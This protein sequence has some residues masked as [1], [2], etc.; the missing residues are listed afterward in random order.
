MI[1]LENTYI[2]LKDGRKLSARIWLPDDAQDNPGPANLEYLPYRKRDGTAARDESTY[3]VF[4]EAGYAGVRVDISGTGE[5]DG[6]FDDEYSPRE[7]ADGL[8]VIDWIASQPWCDGNIGMMGISWGGFNSLQ[9]A[10]LRPEPLKAVIAIG[11]T[12]DRYNDDIHYKNGCHLYSNFSWSSVMLCYASRPPDPVLVGDEWK[13]MWIYRLRTQPFPLE[14]WLTHQRR[15]EYWKHGSVCEN[16]EG[17]LIPTLVISGWADGYLN[18]PP[19]MVEN[20]LS[21]SRAINGPWIH[22]YPHFAWPKPRMDFHGEAIAWWDRWLKGIENGVE[23]MPGYR[24]YISER[25]RPVGYRDFESGRWVAETQWPSPNIK[26]TGFY[27]ADLG[28]LDLRSGDDER[29]TVCSPQDCGISCG[30]IF[31]LKPD[32]E[33]PGDQRI[34]DGGSLVFDSDV[35]PQ[36]VEILGRPTLS[37]RV[38]I[39][40]PVGN[41]AARLCDVHPDGMS[42]RVSWGVLNLAHREGNEYPSPMIPGIDEDITIQLNECGYRFLPGH[43]LRLSISTAYWPMVMPPPEVTIANIEMGRNSILTLPVRSGGDSIRVAEPA[44]PNPLPNYKNHSPDAHQRSVT[45]DM[46]HNMTHYRVFDDT[47]E[48]EV[49]G[50]GMRT[51]HTHEEVWSIS[52]EDP[53]S[54]AA[55]SEYICYMS[56]ENWRIRTVSHSSMACDA[57][58]YYLKASVD[59]YE[60]DELVNNRHWEKTIKRCFQ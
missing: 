5:S 43:R 40:K 34:D 32:S 14:V 55:T 3:P 33:M 15:D 2:T 44:N 53:L 37:L 38:N 12:V 47:G 21:V 24:A 49:P 20:S 57:E 39:D 1:E 9:L 31:T 30:E 42:Y 26:N 8:E 19:A 52:P 56:R 7:H 16:Y 29:V 22:K 4:A 51:R 10:A 45:R 35:L 58:N 41:L 6:D 11:T 50:H 46:Q 60:G 54:S 27:L 28:K 25:V 13:K 59:A 17:I 36:A 23:E 18:A 48:D